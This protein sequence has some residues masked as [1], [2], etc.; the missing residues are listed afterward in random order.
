MAKKSN[1]HKISKSN[2]KHFVRRYVRR[3]PCARLVIANFLLF[4][5]LMAILG[6]VIVVVIKT[7]T[8][9]ERYAREEQIL[10]K[11]SEN[12]KVTLN[13][14]RYESATAWFSNLCGESCGQ[15]STAWRRF[16]LDPKETDISCVSRMEQIDCAVLLEANG[17]KKTCLPELR[18]VIPE[19][20]GT[21][22]HYLKG[23][24]AIDN[25]WPKLV[26]APRV[27]NEQLEELEDP[28][29][30]LVEANQLVIH[31]PICKPQSNFFKYH[32]QKSTQPCVRKFATLVEG[33]PQAYM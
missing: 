20:S 18:T 4:F 14:C 6:I 32:H 12:E 31:C 13:Y 15:M 16:R 8:E 5:F 3:K 21:Y 19:C 25:A 27:T 30:K 2:Y 23:I 29:T 1:A 11:M 10:E 7:W 24:G 9:L 33:W 26:M 17:V 22:Q 28:E